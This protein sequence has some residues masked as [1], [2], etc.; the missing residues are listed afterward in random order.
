MSIFPVSKIAGIVGGELIPK[1]PTAAHLVSSI[2]IDSRT[3]ADAGQCLFF[4]L[5]GE[6]HN[7]HRYIEELYHQGVRN[8]VVSEYQKE[9][10]PFDDAC[11]ILVENSLEALQRLAAFLRSEFQFPILSIT[12]SNG[13]TIVKEWLFELLQHQQKIG[14]SPKSYNSQVGVPLSIWNMAGDFD[15]GILEAGISKPVEM[16]KLAA[17]IRP[18]IGLVTNIGDAHQE[19]FSSLEEKLDE[20]LKLFQASDLLIYR[21]DQQLVADLAEK[22]CKNSK[23]VLFSWSTKGLEA[24]LPITIKEENKYTR[25]LFQ[26][27]GVEKEVVIPFCDEASI[28]NAC[29]CL[30]IIIAKDWAV[31]S[32]FEAFENLQPVAMR[33]ELKQGINNCILINDFYNSDINS[34]EIALQFL[35]QQT[36][37]SGQKKTIILSDIKQSGFAAGQLYAEVNRLLKRN[38]IKRLIGIGKSIHSHQEIFELEAQFYESTQAFINDFQQAAFKDEAILIKGAREFRFER[39]ASLL[40]KKYHQTQLEI[41]LNTL[42]ENLNVFKSVLRPGTKVMAMVKAFSYGSG[43]VEIARALEFQ[44][45]DYLA[46]AVADE[47]IE[48]RQAGIDTPIIVMNPE[49]H[50]FEAMIEYRLEPNIYSKKVFESF[51]EAAQS[52]AVNQYPV[53]IK[54][55][56][57]MNRLG[58]LNEVELEEIAEQIQQE[59]VLRVQSVFSHLAASDDPAHD[60][61]THEQ[62]ERFMHLVGLVISRQKNKVLRHLLNSSG[63]ERFPSYQMEMVRLG[64]GLYGVAATEAVHVR[65]IARWTSSISQVKVVAAN[66]TVGYSRKGKLCQPSK[67]AVIPVGYA[68]GYDRRFSNGVGKMWVNGSLAPVIGNVCMDMA[69]IDVT[70]NEVEEGDLV[71]LMGEHITLKSLA[72]WAETIPYEILTGISQRVKRVYSQE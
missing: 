12:G 11:F 44:K 41:N 39:V 62:Y 34:L 46:V 71:E 17:M 38:Q 7:G 68:D 47:G 23:T 31:P 36:S 6:R 1:N 67:I 15:L 37:S 33:L 65:P 51:N 10:F 18:Q 57:G 5:V 58:F 13:K 61:F 63:I 35:G 64:I 45:V 14:R 26:W 4:A 28:E 42:V 8:F 21:K 49:E 22:K 54:L 59:N 53:H 72:E 20:K 3:L 55:E 30:A 32:V 69:M 50:S 24:D 66:E 56:T 29:H 16:D 25:M 48:L 70:G 9:L 19:N 43:T 52:S 2:S 60:H 27:H 40:Q